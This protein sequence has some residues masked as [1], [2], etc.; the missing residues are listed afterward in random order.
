[1]LDRPHRRRVSF[2]NSEKA[3]RPPM[4]QLAVAMAPALIMGLR[5]R[6]AV[7]SSRTMEL[8]GSPVGSTPTLLNT[9][10]YPA[11]WSARMR[12]MVL[13]ML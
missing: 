11:S 10:R 8:N 12:V 1:M 7:V 13:E 4:Q 5:G 3:S 9:F 2:R 6:G